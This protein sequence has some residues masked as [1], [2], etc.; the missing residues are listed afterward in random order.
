MEFYFIYIHIPHAGKKCRS[1]ALQLRRNLMEAKGVTNLLPNWSSCLYLLSTEIVGIQHYTRLTHRG[2]ELRASRVLG[3][4]SSNWAASP[5]LAKLIF[6][7]VKPVLWFWITHSLSLVNYC[8][9]SFVCVWNVRNHIFFFP[10][11]ELSIHQQ[12]HLWVPSTGRYQLSF[13]HLS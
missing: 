1:S 5:V 4:H 2:L 8:S 6:E 12:I 3:Q 9:G 10:G 13:V 7:W 11:G